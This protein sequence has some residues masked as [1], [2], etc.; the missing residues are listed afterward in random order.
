MRLYR[1]IVPGLVVQAVMVGGGYATG[2]ELV[3][4]FLSKG[5]ATALAGL[6]LT[7]LLISTGAVV[8]F[9]LA[10]QYLAFDYKSFCRV[11][12]GRFWV[13]FEIGYYALLVLVL[14]VLS[15]AAGKLLAQM[16]GLPELTNS[17]LFIVVVAFVVFFGNTV[18]EKV[19][20]AWSVLF[21]ATYGAMFAMV[22]LKFGPELRTALHA[23]A[24][25][26]PEAV[27]DSF[28]YTGYNVVILPILIFVARNFE[29]R[30]DALIAGMVAGPLILLPGLASLLALSAF[31]PSILN[32]PLPISVVLGN[33]GHPV[34]ATCV[35]L[36]ILGAFVKTGVGLLHGLNERIARAATD[37][38]RTLPRAFRPIAA[39]VILVVTVF[40]ASAVGIIDLIGRGYR[41]SSYFFLLIFFFPLLLRGTWLVVR[42]S[43]GARVRPE[44]IPS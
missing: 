14:S 40:V 1:Y 2:R 41:Y 15:A 4:F 35:Q 43:G 19:I 8:S 16:A 36:V 44:V 25:D 22:L 12:L 5:P 20:S 7:A 42:G 3:E 38:G 33:I 31:Y 13:L 27:R 32:E 9:E 24:F 34:L 10:R 26:W 29:S 23:S 6:A 18:I 28:S 11:F 17:I 21:Y 37:R 39:L 30:A